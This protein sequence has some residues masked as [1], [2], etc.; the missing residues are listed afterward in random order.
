MKKLIII[1]A[2]CFLVGC[3][4]TKPVEKQAVKK[5]LEEDPESYGF[6]IIK[7]PSKLDKKDIYFPFDELYK[8]GSLFPSKDIFEKKDKTG[9]A[10]YRH[11]IDPK[12]VESGFSGH[13]TRKNLA[14][15]H[16][17]MGT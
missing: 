5:T 2:V 11:K 14:Q 13:C 8:D 4:G 6:T 12:V 16:R 1:I 9:D 17:S 15:D 7:D 10:K 3:G